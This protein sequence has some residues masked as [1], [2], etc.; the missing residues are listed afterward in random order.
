MLHESVALMMSGLWVDGKLWR[1]EGPDSFDLAPWLDEQLLAALREYLNGGDLWI[2]DGE[3]SFFL[4]Y[5]LDEEFKKAP[6]LDLVKNNVEGHILPDM[7]LSEEGREVA[8]KLR[9][10]LLAAVEFIDGALEG[11]DA[12]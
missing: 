2:E 12:S 1:C 8:F 9:T 11:G 4:A 5:P 7:T 10:A 6:L 3:V